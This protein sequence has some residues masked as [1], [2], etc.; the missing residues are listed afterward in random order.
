L[1]LLFDDLDLFLVEADLSLF[2]FLKNSPNLDCLSSTSL[3]SR[4]LVLNSY[5]Y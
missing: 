3:L 2:Y 4:F 1:L 5:Y